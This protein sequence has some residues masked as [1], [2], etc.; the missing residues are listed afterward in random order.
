MKLKRA[1]LAI[2]IAALAIIIILISLKAYYVAIT[3]LAGILLILHREIWSLVKSR[4]FPPID[5]RTKENINK[6]VRNGFVFLVIALVFAMLFLS[7][8]QTISLDIVHIIGSLLLSGGAVYLLSYIFYEQ[9]EPKLNEKAIKLL[10][11]FMMTSII[12]LGV[13][14]ISIIIHNA[15]S[16]LFGIEEPVFFTIAVILSPFSLIVGIVG[17]LVIL[18]RGPVTQIS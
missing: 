2:P 17:S 18:F 13:I 4:K 16:A 3:L 11:A 5:E 9:S 12:S 1:L 10:R 8:N 7:T 6:S 15:L 14:I